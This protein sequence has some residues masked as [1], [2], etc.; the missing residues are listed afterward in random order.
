MSIR[1]DGDS[2]VHRFCEITG[3]RALPHASREGDAV[4][5]IT[6]VEIKKATAGTISQVRA[7]KYV[8]LVVYRPEQDEWIVV[9]APDLIRMI[10]EGQKHGQHGASP[11]ICCSFSVRSIEQYA[12]TDLSQAVQWAYMLGVQHP[13]LREAMMVLQRRVDAQRVDHLNYVAD[14]LPTERLA[15]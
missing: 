12:T 7:V 6:A 11:F 9:P 14:F 1:F 4:L 3:A 5:G 10:V 15:A 8:P 2:A 13:K